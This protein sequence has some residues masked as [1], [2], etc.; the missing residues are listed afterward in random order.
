[1]YS[2]D[3]LYDYS[4]L[5][6][7]AAIIKSSMVFLNISGF[8]ISTSCVVIKDAVEHESV[9]H[10]LIMWKRLSNPRTAL[11]LSKN[12]STQTKCLVC[13]SLFVLMETW[14]I[15]M[16]SFQAFLP[17]TSA[18]LVQSRPLQRVCIL[19]SQRVRGEQCMG[20]WT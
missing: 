20:D 15:G 4:S 14:K 16:F 19:L 1:M 11:I 13:D 7:F 3:V 9:L 10:C 6:I 18:P 12:R 8:F 2:A 5:L 17:N